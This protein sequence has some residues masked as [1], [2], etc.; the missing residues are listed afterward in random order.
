[1]LWKICILFL[2]SEPLHAGIWDSESS[3]PVLRLK[4]GPLV[5]TERSTIT[6]TASTPTTRKVTESAESHLQFPEPG[7]AACAQRPHPSLLRPPLLQKPEA[8]GQHLGIPFWLPSPLIVCALLRE[9]QHNFPP[10]GHVTGYDV[11]YLRAPNDLLHSRSFCFTASQ[12]EVFTPNPILR[13]T[14][15]QRLLC[16]AGF[17]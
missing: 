9:C 5:L 3:H 4:E 12:V 14:L 17:C 6:S 15:E 8:I 2:A 16:L 11:L 1:M 7:E 13:Q 10:D